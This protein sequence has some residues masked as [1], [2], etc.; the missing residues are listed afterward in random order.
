MQYKNAHKFQEATF[1]I[2][3]EFLDRQIPYFVFCWIIYF[4]SLLFN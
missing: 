3:N 1:P 4:S 2:Q